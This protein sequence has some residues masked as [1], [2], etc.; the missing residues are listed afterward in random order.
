MLPTAHCPTKWVQVRIPQCTRFE[1]FEN[2][3]DCTF[4]TKHHKLET[5][6]PS[7]AT[8]SLPSLVPVQLHN[9]HSKS[10]KVNLCYR[11]ILPLYGVPPTAAAIC[12]D[13]GA[14]PK[15]YQIKPRI[16]QA[17]NPMACA[18]NDSQTDKA[19]LLIYVYY[20]LIAPNNLVTRSKAVTFLRVYPD[21]RH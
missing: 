7:Y 9:A 15:V 17:S 10:C 13:K 6:S 2:G 12:Y 11:W 20:K 8:A 3:L 19:N 4:Q 1:E 5:L 18:C 14:G 21:I 16:L